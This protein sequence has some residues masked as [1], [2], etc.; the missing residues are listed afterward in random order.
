[1]LTLLPQLGH[2]LPSYSLIL[3]KKTKMTFLFDNDSYTG[4]GCFFQ[5]SMTSGIKVH[6]PR[7]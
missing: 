6:I 2:V 7:T 1:V 3:W 4:Q 5:G